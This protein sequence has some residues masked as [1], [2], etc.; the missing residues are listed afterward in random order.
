MGA[1]DVVEGATSFHDTSLEDSS[2]LEAATTGS[3]IV[4]AVAAS[5]DGVATDVAD[6][7]AL[8]PVG[9]HLLGGGSCLMHLGGAL[10]NGRVDR[11]PDHVDLLLSVEVPPDDV[12]GLDK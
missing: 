3:L 4:A 5:L 11:G 12:V 2:L 6:S 1:L 10:L 9:S 7:L 8:E